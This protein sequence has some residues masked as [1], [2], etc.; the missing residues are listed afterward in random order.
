MLI[1]LSVPVIKRSKLLGGYACG[2]LRITERTEFTP[3][4]AQARK[5]GPQGANVQWPGTPTAR[6]RRE[7]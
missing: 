7:A 6:G 5:K 1:T 2:A 4:P 3:S